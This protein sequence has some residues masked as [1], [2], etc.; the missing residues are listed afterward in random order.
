MRQTKT[1][2][3]KIKLPMTFPQAWSNEDINFYLNDS[4]WCCSNLIPLLREY[5]D[6]NGCI[7][8][9]TQCSVLEE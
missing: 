4:S 8:G 7:C 9:I 3:I 5:S 6:T 2:E 1:I